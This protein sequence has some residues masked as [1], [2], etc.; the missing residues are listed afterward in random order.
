[1]SLHFGYSFQQTQRGTSM[2]PL[3]KQGDKPRTRETS[4]TFNPKPKIMIPGKKHIINLSHDSLVEPAI[5][6]DCFRKEI[7]HNKQYK[8][9]NKFLF[10][11]TDIHITITC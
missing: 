1:M 4:P 10:V 11:L 3:T 2:F 9:L 7:P 5:K 6:M 8:R